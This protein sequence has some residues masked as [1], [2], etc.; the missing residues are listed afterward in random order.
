MANPE[1]RNPANPRPGPLLG[2][3][4]RRART[5]PPRLG[6]QTAAGQTAELTVARDGPY[7]THEHCVTHVVKV[8]KQVS[9]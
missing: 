6:S 1:F 2:P 8:A 5:R 3:A 4:G 9:T 7:E